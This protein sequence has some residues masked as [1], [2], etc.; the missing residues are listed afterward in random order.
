MPAARTR[1]RAVR[2]RRPDLDPGVDPADLVPVGADALSGLVGQL[3]DAGLS[4]FVVRPVAPVA[5][6]DEELDWL[7]EAVL[8]RQT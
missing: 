2:P 8:P 5:D 1:L 4:K 6:W 7:A 3:V